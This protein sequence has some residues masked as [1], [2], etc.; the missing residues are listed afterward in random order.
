MG[1][2]ARRGRLTLDKLTALYA[3]I[4][5]SFDET[6]LAVCDAG[7]QTIHALLS[8][9]VE[10]HAPYAGVVPE[11]AAR[12]HQHLPQ[13]WREFADIAAAVRTSA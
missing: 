3:A 11:L 2:A 10:L 1:R 9:Q 8:S 13:M 6:A 4:E 12:T 5:T 7:G